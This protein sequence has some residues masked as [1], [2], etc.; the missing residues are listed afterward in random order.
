MRRFWQIEFPAGDARRGPA[1]GER[2][3][4]STVGIVSAVGAALGGA[5]SLVGALGGGGGGGAAPAPSAPTVMPT[6]DD[7][8]ARAAKRKSLA[9]QA[10]RRGRQSTILSDPTAGSDI[11]G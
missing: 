5:G 4:P 8:A 2:F 6:P 3:D 11:L 1:F 10:Q 7:E 9:A